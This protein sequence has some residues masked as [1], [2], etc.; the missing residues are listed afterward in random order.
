MKVKN[1]AI[2][3]KLSHR[4]LDVKKKKNIISIL[5]II[6]TTV[7]FT[8][9]F[10][11]GGSMIKST[12]ESTMLQVGMSTHAGFERLTKKQFDIVS[13]DPKIHGV[14]YNIFVGSAINPEFKNFPVEVR[15]REDL[16]AKYT[17]SE[18]EEGRM[19]EK[20]NEI[21]ASSLVLKDLGVP[22]ELG[23]TVTLDILVN[24]KTIRQT[25]TLVGYWEGNQGMMA[26]DVNVSRVFAEA[27][28]PTPKEPYYANKSNYS[29]YIDMEVNFA[30]AWNIQ[31]QVDALMERCGFDP[32]QVK[33]GVNWAYE[34]D[35]IEP[36]DVFVLAG[37][38]LL[39]VLS[40]YLI[41]YNVFYLNVF[42]DIRFYGLLKTIGTTG[43]Q[44]RKIVRKQAWRLC[45]FGIPAGLLIGWCAGRVLAPIMMGVLEQQVDAYSANPL[46]FVGA[47]IFTVFT[48]HISCIKPC[49]MAARISPVEAMK[50]TG[51][52]TRKK[53]RRTHGFHTWSMAA[54]NLGRNKKKLALVAGSLSLSLIILNSVYTTVQGFDMD[55]FLESVMISDY[56]VTD[57]SI[58]QYLGYRELQG[59]TKE[60]E[61]A[62]RN[63]EGVENLSEIYQSEGNHV[64]S[65]TEWERMEQIM[66]E[67]EFGEALEHPEDLERIK[68]SKMDFFTFYGIDEQLAEEIMVDGKPL[69]W[70]VFQ[71][72]D[73]I[74]VNQYNTVTNENNMPLFQVGESVKLTFA[75]GT[76]KEYQILGIAELPNAVGDQTYGYPFEVECILPAEELKAQEGEMQPMRVI[77]DAKEGYE[78]EVTSW[79]KA[80]C[81]GTENSLAY[82]TKGDYLEEFGKMRQMYSI[83][84]GALS[85]ILAMIGI[86]NF[87]NVIATSILS[88]KQEFAM[89]E[90]I[91]MTVGQQKRILWAEGLFYAA[92]TILLSMSLGSIV[93]Y[94][95]VKTVTAQMWMFRYQ[96]TLT[97]ILLS[98][99]FLLLITWL[100]PEI[101]Y[102]RM[103]RATVVERLRDVEN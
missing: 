60:F 26:Q 75:N 3:Q 69:D 65:D 33:C 91:G 56:M 99:P 84:G 46:I 63:Q 15:S 48:V 47:T 89:M 80:V 64:F 39:I 68:E 12:R 13:K 21:A 78:E 44:L 36:A 43:R 40:G 11:I 10:T 101:C 73:Y 96:F 20:R 28:A 92:I 94:G 42:H 97:P 9:V 61:E 55:K 22:C 18:P 88:R 23:E 95:V 8:A 53:S 54:A 57:R 34:T 27:V 86:L 32:Q 51:Q 85:L 59:V 30:T 102:R 5:A 52:K 81:D 83:A 41:I 72:G 49:R 19:P 93:S 103:R 98:I 77:F 45:L 67:P 1:K 90:S 16:D 58:V 35:S 38:L 17:F 76:E 74:L 37:L 4:M 66:Q 50:Y 79:L 24:E 82:K 6:L 31:K 70:N 100:V 62:L 2:I 29:G 87:V 14:S 25:F 7:L 71:S